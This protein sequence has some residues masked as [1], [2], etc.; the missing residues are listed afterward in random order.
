[1]PD[2]QVKIIDE[3]ERALPAGRE[4]EICVRGPNVTSGYHGN[5]QATK[6]T[7]TSDGWLK[8]GDIG[9]QDNEGFLFIRD[10]KKDMIIVK[11]LKVY[12]AQ[13][14]AVAHEHPAV[15]E[16]AVIGVPDAYGE[17]IIKCFATLK[18]GASADKHEILKFLRARLDP[19]KRPR[20]VEILDTL[21]K[22]TLNKI[23]KRDLRRREAEKLKSFGAAA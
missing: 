23:L 17:E 21:P 10:R 11:G 12:P 3:H 14:E 22:N 9:V 13:V 6:E 2:V 1:V 15:A 20:D 19:Y 18:P 4:G 16:A 5:R 7:F 8:T